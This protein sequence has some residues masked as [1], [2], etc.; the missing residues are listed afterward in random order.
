DITSFSVRVFVLAVACIW[1]LGI[2]VAQQL[3]GDIIVFIVSAVFLE[4]YLIVNLLST[5]EANQ[6][7]SL[8]YVRFGLATFFFLGIVAFC[9]L[10]ILPIYCKQP[11]W[12]VYRLNAAR[13]TQRMIRT[14]CSSLSLIVLDVQLQRN[15]EST[16]W[17]VVFGILLLPHLVYIIFRMQEIAR[18]AP[19]ESWSILRHAIFACGSLALVTRLAAA[20]CMIL[21]ARNFGNEINQM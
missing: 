12:L 19:R 11:T 3:A 4:I 2:G 17:L 18:E 10:R 5:H 14:F 16:C 21:V 9:V 15:K 7:P 8:K 20:F 6:H 1:H 13:A